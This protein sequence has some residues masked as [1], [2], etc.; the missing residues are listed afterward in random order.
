[1]TPSRVFQALNNAPLSPQTGDNIVAKA[2]I[3]VGGG[4]T[5]FGFSA[6][7]YAASPGLLEMELWLD[8][9][10]TGGRLSMY[11]NLAETHLALGHSWVYVP[12][13]SNGDHDIALV[14]GTNT[15]TDQNDRAC[16]TGWEM[17]DGCA[18]RFSE[19]A[20]CPQGSGGTLLDANFPTK[21]NQF[22]VSGAASGWVNSEGI[23]TARM[24]VDG[25]T[26][27]ATQVFANNSSEHLATVPTDFLHTTGTQ[28]GQHEVTM[29]A[30]GQVATDSGDTAH[31]AVVEWLNPADAPVVCAMNP[32]LVGAVANAQHGDG[33]SIAQSQFS[34]GNGRLL[35][36]VGVSV[37]TEGTGGVPLYVGIQ[38]D[39]TSLGF[40][41]I[42]A[43]ANDTHMSMVTN[44]LVLEN[45]PPGVHTL[46]LMG[47]ANTITDSNDRVSVTIMEFPTP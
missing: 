11:A 7:A 45:V 44:D 5:L 26:S 15:V 18:V 23:I 20:P 22:L 37:W 29:V 27:V 42:W 38:I 6:S 33:G 13:V 3:S 41:E 8:G 31:L 17:G 46:N 34:K 16:V 9:Q 32:P 30:D 25:D 14:A 39:G 1:M 10:P 2:P 35:V 43:N 47:E 24:V 28:H 36:K 19:D 12:G 21:G 4:D 40:C